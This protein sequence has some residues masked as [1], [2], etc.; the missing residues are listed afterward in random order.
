MIQAREGGSF[1]CSGASRQVAPPISS[2]DQLEW[3][4]A[5]VQGFGDLPLGPATPLLLG[6]G[7]LSD[8]SG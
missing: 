7:E 8:Q 1:R 6:G 3:L 2:P 4:M 5:Q